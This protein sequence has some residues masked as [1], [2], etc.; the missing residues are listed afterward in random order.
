MELRLSDSDCKPVN[1]TA[2]QLSAALT[3]C[4]ALVPSVATVPQTKLI[5][6]V[7]FHS[8]MILRVPCRYLGA[9]LE[10]A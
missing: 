5:A 7:L 4:T 6:L 9:Q 1:A 3:M 8:G 2:A 10:Y